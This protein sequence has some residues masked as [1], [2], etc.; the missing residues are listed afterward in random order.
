MSGQIL[1]TSGFLAARMNV[2]QVAGI[3]VTCRSGLRE[4][5]NRVGAD[6]VVLVRERAGSIK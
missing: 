3:E 1:Q 5:Q 2:R 6:Q 4:S